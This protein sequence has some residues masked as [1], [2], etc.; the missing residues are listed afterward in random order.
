M[1]LV[2]YGTL[3]QGHPNHHLLKGSLFLGEVTLHGYDMYSVYGHYPAVTYGDG[4]I[5][6][7][8]YDVDNFDQLDGLEGF[9]G[10]DN[11]YNVYN[12]VAFNIEEGQKQVV[13]I[14]IYNRNVSDMVQI[15]NGIWDNN[16][17]GIGKN[18]V[19]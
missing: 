14:Y 19:V 11:K 16:S 9:Y 13:Y 18:K 6:C 8:L 10:D 1:L 12:R 2:V 3:K 7:E 17:Y 5:Q 15:T 4:S